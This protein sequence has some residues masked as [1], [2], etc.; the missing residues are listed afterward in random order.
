MLP[1]LDS[2]LIPEVGPGV[3]KQTT[4]L[5]LPAGAETLSNVGPIEAPFSSWAF[6]GVKCAQLTEQTQ[7]I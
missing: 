3:E 5:L 7:G 2:S 1:Y 4:W 6:E